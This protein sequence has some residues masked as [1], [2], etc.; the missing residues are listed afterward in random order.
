[1]GRLN[2]FL[3]AIAG[4]LA[5]AVAGMAHALVQCAP[6]APTARAEQPFQVGLHAQPSDPG[7][8]HQAADASVDAAASGR[9]HG[10]AKCQAKT[11]H[12][13]EGAEFWSIL[14]Y[15]LK[16]TDTLLAAFTFLLFGATVALWLSTHNLV[17]GADKT[18]ERQL[19][20][21]IYIE[22]T[23]LTCKNDHWELSFCIK[24]F[25]QTPA[26]NVIVRSGS[27]AVDWNGGPASVPVPSRTDSLGSMG[28]QGDVFEIVPE[29][30]DT[31]SA[32]RPGLENKTKALFVA[33]TIEYTTV[34]GGPHRTDFRYYVGGDKGYS[35][36]NL[37]GKMFADKA[38]NDST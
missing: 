14:G 5:I 31:V 12:D 9:E 19:R 36:A 29:I 28:P 33:D 2:T 6:Y 30:A 1:M 11:P 23:N 18:A 38:G 20:A 8:G 24:N 4:S 25:G 17:R 10:C 15:R 26:H 3:L 7:K 32:T 35:D 34:F 16:V 37:D 22:K 21:Y 13:E 27:A